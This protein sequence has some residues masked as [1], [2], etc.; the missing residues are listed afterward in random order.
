VQDIFGRVYDA[1]GEPAL[2]AVSLPASEPS[3]DRAYFEVA[4]SVK[5]SIYE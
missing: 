3:M 1:Q 4:L 2:D 5:T